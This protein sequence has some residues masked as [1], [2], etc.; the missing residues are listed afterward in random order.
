VVA[1]QRYSKAADLSTAQ[2]ETAG[3]VLLNY[4]ATVLLSP[5]Y[6]NGSTVLYNAQVGKLLFLDHPQWPQVDAM[7]P[8]F[9]HF[10]QMEFA[11]PKRWL[12]DQAH[13]ATTTLPNPPPPLTIEGIVKE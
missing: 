2:L 1:I 10:C 12:P 3:A 4:C 5:P 6:I 8:A 13:A 7:P 9:A 11:T